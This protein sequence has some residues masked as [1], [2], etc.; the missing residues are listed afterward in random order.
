MNIRNF[1][2]NG[3]H[4]SRQQKLK[5]SLNSPSQSMYPHMFYRAYWTLMAH[6]KCI[7][8]LGITVTDDRGINLLLGGGTGPFRVTGVSNIWP[9]IIEQQ[10][11][12]VLHRTI[13]YCTTLYC[14]ASDFIEAVPCP[15]ILPHPALSCPHPLLCSTRSCQPHSQCHRSG[16]GSGSGTK[17]SNLLGFDAVTS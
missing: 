7:P 6:I 13:L 8:K 10:I 17:R 15:V 16:R 14:T 9:V 3:N 11:Y 2:K 4:L 12:L 5:R 1:C